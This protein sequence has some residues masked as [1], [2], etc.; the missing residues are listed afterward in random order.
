MSISVTAPS[1]KSISHRLLM[2]AALAEGESR[3]SNILESKDTERTGAVLAACGVGLAR[4]MHL[5]G[6]GLFTVQGVNG[7][8]RGGKSLQ[9]PVLCD[10]HESGTSCRLLTALLAAGSGYFKVF[11]AQRLHERP[12]AGLT[13]ALKGLGAEFIWL[14][15]EDYPPFVLSAGSLRGGEAV[16]PGEDSSQYASGLLLAAP[17]MPGGLSLRFAGGAV[18]SWPY[19]LLTLQ[20]MA[21]FG[22]EFAVE[23]RKGGA[24]ESVAWRELK[25]IDPALFRIRVWPGA[26]RAGEY[27]GEGDWSSASYLLAAGALG[28]EPV[29]VRGL[30]GD[31]LQGDRV[32]ADILA[33]MGAG[34]DFNAAGLTVSPPPEGRPLRGLRVDMGACPDLT[35]TVAALAAM[36][37][38]PSEIYGAAH[39]RLKESDRISAPATELRK[40]GCVVEELADGMRIIPPPRLALASGSDGVFCTHNDHRLAM[41]LTL[42]TRRGIPVKLDNPEC[43]DKSFPDFNK[44]WQEISRA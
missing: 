12:M 44:V 8:L 19:L 31:S 4:A 24:W 10:M 37:E 17:L 38:G 20:V 2:A 26:Y 40:V 21:D 39:L 16:V 34:I 23:T 32:I 9:S 29:T 1:S 27:N 28:P 36:A 5:Q 6:A 30:R 33:A 42:L 11:G 3:L 13:T 35:P 25:G 18:N 15:K 22:I 41:S 43:V 7:R 14:G